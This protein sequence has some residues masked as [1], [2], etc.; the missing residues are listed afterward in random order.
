MSYS[1]VHKFPASKALQLFF[2]PKEFRAEKPVV[3]FKAKSVSIY[4]DMQ[5]K[6]HKAKPS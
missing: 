1:Y 3:K 4:V 5:G 6:G 2:P